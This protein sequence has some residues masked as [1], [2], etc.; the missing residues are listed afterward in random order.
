MSSKLKFSWFYQKDE[1]SSGYVSVREAA[2]ATVWKPEC[3]CRASTKTH[4]L[5]QNMNKNISGVH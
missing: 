2:C 5:G 3:G 1:H 4:C